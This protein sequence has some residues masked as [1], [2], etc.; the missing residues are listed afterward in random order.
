MGTTITFTVLYKD[1]LT[2]ET[3]SVSSIEKLRAEGK[4]L[5]IH[6]K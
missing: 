2:E 4:K 1:T 6:L 3:M 5:I